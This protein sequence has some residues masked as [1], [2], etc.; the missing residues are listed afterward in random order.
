MQISQHTRQTQLSQYS[1]HNTCRYCS[2]HSTHSTHSTVYTTHADIAAHTAHTVLTVQYTQHMHTYMY[3]THSTHST[4][5]IYSQYTYSIHNTC[6]H[7]QYT[8][9]VHTQQHLQQGQSHKQLS[10]PVYCLCTK[11]FIG[12]FVKC[13]VQVALHV[14]L[15]HYTNLA[16]TACVN[17]WHYNE[18]IVHYFQGLYCQEHT[19]QTGASYSTSIIRPSA[20]L[21]AMWYFA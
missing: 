6:T 4:H 11:Y 17:P 20:L 14:M 8:Q 5:S 15:Q 7:V 12:Q 10:G 21:S 13:S 19:A 2:T 3:S 16:N 18:F 1:I 9:H